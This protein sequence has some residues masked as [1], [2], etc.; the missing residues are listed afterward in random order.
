[1]NSGSFWKVFEH[2][3]SVQSYLNYKKDIEEQH[4][5]SQGTAQAGE[6]YADGNARA[7]SAGSESRGS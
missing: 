6:Q 5:Q 3:G 7:G 2:T 4:D 1:M